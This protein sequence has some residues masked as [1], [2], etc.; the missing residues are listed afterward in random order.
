MA[1]NID[2][3]KVEMSPIYPNNFDFPGEKQLTLVLRV[4]K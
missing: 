1:D 3:A 2:T 4:D